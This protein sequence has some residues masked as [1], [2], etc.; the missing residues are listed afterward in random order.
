MGV[1]SLGLGFKAGSEGQFSSSRNLL[2]LIPRPQSDVR[3][4]TLSPDNLKSH[5]TIPTG[6]WD[7]VGYA[8][9]LLKTKPRA[10]PV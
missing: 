2:V 10:E 3:S 7:P 4:T 5:G 9:V 8:E 6:C 1:S